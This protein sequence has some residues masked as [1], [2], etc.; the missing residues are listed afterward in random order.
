MRLL[1][2]AE[3]INRRKGLTQSS[4]S[5]A[6]AVEDLRSQTK[7]ATRWGRYSA[8]TLRNMLTEARN[9]AKNPMY[10]LWQAGGP[11]GTWPIEETKR[12]RKSILD[13][14]SITRN[15]F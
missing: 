12:I 6:K 3:V 4:A 13:F 7:F 10:L 9:P 2:D 8:R 1:A 14:F 15:G 11:T 5:D